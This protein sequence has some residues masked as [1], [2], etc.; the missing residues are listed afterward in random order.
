MKT[1]TRTQTANEVTILDASPASWPIMSYLDNGNLPAIA[2]TAA[3]KLTNWRK[4]EKSLASIIGLAGIG[5]AGW[6]VFKYVL[7]VVFGALGQVMA[8]IAS[9]ALIVFAWMASPAVYKL[10]RR[11]VR[12]MHR[13]LI[14]WDPFAELDDQLAKMKNSLAVFLRNKAKIKKLRAEFA[15]MSDSSEKTAGELQESI[16]ID[17]EKAAKLKQQRDELAVRIQEA[18]AKADQKLASELRDLHTELEQ[19]FSN[20]VAAA[21]RNKSSME[22]NIEWT[23]K[24]AARSNIFA[25]LDRKL[26]LG[27]TK[28]ENKIKDFELSI[29]D[30]KRDWEM[31]LASRGATDTL[32]QIL[33][34]GGPNWQLDYALEYV[35]GR[36]NEDLAITAQNLEDLDRYTD[37]FDFDSDDAYARL[38]QTVDKIDMGQVPVPDASDIY[39]P[40]HR[41]KSDEKNAAGLLGNL[42]DH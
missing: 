14:R 39:N 18:D 3:N 20:A 33:G 36:I 34:P 22:R 8:I 1:T 10:F 27:S 24:Y 28:I 35:T 11:L 21:Q 4:G 31:A 17:A 7:P 13:A 16:R 6:G 30:M 38:V 29:A 40:S 32:V 5:V 41:L 23:K 26:A 25:Q 9:V 15:A 2:E 19:K 42:F 37:G 12:N